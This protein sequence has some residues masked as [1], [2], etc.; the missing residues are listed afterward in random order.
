[1][2]IPWRYIFTEEKYD[3][4]SFNP[5]NKE[6]ILLPRILFT[7]VILKYFQGLKDQ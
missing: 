6:Y 3:L 5:N 1:M 7:F 2:F 4:N